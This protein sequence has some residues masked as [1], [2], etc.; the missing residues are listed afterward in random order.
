MGAQKLLLVQAGSLEV[1]V[2][3]RD[4]ALLGVWEDEYQL[5]GGLW[6]L[7]RA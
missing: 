4:A 6:G 3:G 1:A 5:S 2:T 7:W